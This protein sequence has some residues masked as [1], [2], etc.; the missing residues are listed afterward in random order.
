MSIFLGTSRSSKAPVESTT[1]SSWG[2]NGSFTDWLPA[3][4][5][6]CLKR[7]ACV[8]PSALLTVRWLAS[9]NSPTPCTTVTLRA[10]AMP[11]RPP[12]SLATTLSL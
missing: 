10:F 6:A 8:L 1:R 7:M 9:A 12:V 5:M 11:A 2:M 4:M 3:A